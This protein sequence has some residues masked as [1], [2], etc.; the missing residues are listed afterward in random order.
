MQILA[1]NK[2]RSVQVGGNAR[3]RIEGGG[4]DSVKS[5]AERKGPWRLTDQGNDERM[6]L[7]ARLLGCFLLA[8]ARATG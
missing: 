2:V 1:V 3:P 4:Q 5:E 7:A 8:G 6:G